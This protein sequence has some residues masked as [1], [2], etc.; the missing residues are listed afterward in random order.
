M[1]YLIA[2]PEMLAAAAADVTAIGS[3][4]G[5]ANSTAA[6]STTTMLAAAEDEVSTA[7][8]SLFSS[9]AQE[10]QTLSRQAALF[11]TQFVQ[12]L[13]GAGN[14]YAAAEAASAHPL[15]ALLDDMLAVINAPTNFLLG[16]P[17]IG[18]GSDGGPGSGAKG[19]A[20]GILVGN[21]G[22][23]GSGAP[24]QAGGDGGAAGLLGIGGAGGAGGI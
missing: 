20:G 10:Y 14:A 11:H 24:G 16:R 5:T 13:T 6:A 18:N 7:I 19:G 15:Q 9:H 12:A 3:S 17:L 22:N 21:G 2:I 1:S 23:G 8:A 4:V